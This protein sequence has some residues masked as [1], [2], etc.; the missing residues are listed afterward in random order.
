MTLLVALGMMVTAAELRAGDAPAPFTWGADVSSSIDVGGN[1]MSSINVDAY[2]GYRRPYIDMLGIGA[3][4][5]MML[6]NNSRAFPVYAI[7]RS[8]FRTDPSLCFL[9]LRGGVAFDEASDKTK[10]RPFVNPG[11]GFRLAS[12]K[13]FCSYIIV[14]YIYNGFKADSKEVDGITAVDGLNEVNLRIGVTF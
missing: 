2:F 13:T 5:H 12:S 1:D 9:D 4:I 10:A 3:G 7:F 11:V 14:G 6:N 8:N